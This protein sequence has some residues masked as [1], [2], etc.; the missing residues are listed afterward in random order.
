MSAEN[1]EELRNWI[2]NNPG[3]VLE[4]AIFNNEQDKIELSMSYWGARLMATHFNDLLNKSEAVNFLEV[5]FHLGNYQQEDVIVTVQRIN[6]KRPTQKIKEL[7]D[8][9]KQLERSIVLA[10]L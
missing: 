8:Y 4:E 6:G 2:K 3:L 1:L 7:E 9:T 5:Q 10:N